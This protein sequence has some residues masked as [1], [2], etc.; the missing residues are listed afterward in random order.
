VDASCTTLARLAEYIPQWGINKTAREVATTLRS[1][2][3]AEFRF[4]REEQELGLFP[5]LQARAEGDEAVALRALTRRLVDEH[6]AIETQWKDL[7]TALD[8]I[9]L[10]RPVTLST[11]RV[12]SF[13]N[14]YRDHLEREER[15]LI[16]LASRIIGLGDDMTL[17]G[18]NH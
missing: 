9:A 2:F 10:S 18:P 17:T 8:D 1:Y 11:H 5:A 12:A 15:A 4:H 7:R 3:D 6:Q 14:L 13:A 16:E